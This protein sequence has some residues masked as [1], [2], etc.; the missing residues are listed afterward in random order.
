MIEP[1]EKLEILDGTEITVTIDTG[2]IALSKVED[3]NWWK[4][5]GILKGTSAL[6][7]HEQEH[8]KEVEHEKS[9]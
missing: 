1:M 3:S 4:W 9:P 5:R 2:S 8:I 7:E 6:Q